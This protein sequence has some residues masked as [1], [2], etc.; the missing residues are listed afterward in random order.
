MVM[1]L[2]EGVQKD[3][4]YKVPVQEILGKEEG[5][6]AQNLDGEEWANPQRQDGPW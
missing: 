5:V 6:K 2:E 1:F 4:S 3:T